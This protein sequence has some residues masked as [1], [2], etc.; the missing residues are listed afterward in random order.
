MTY[1]DLLGPAVLAWLASMFVSAAVAEPVAPSTSL[2][3]VG[4]PFAA[5]AQQSVAQQ[6]VT[7]RLASDRRFV[8]DALQ[9]QQQKLEEMMV[10]NQAIMKQSQTGMPAESL[11][12][13]RIA[14]FAEVQTGLITDYN[15]LLRLRT[16]GAAQ[17]VNN[18]TTALSLLFAQS[19]FIY[20]SPDVNII[21]MISLPSPTLSSVTVP[22]PGLT[23]PVRGFF[24]AHGQ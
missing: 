13:S 22:F 14:D 12:A 17:G 7:E 1:K 23:A 15:D 10:Q 11:F 24:A 3:L 6:F 5:V 20:G 9:Q 2:L 18:R 4:A 21:S 16:S 19:G 8:A